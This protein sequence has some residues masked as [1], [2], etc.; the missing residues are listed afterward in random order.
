MSEKFIVSVGDVRAYDSNQNI[1]F[2]GKTLIDSSFEQTLG[3][4]PIRGGKGNALLNIYYHTGEV[5][6][7]VTDAQ[8]NLAFLAANVGQT[9]A[10]GGNI[11]VEETVTLGAAGTGTV[12]GTPI[13][14]SGAVIY[15]WLTLP[16]GT[17]ERVTFSSKTWATSTGT[18]G[19]VCCVRY[20]ALN[21]AV[22]QLTIPS[23]VV[24]SQMRLEIDTQLASNNTT[25]TNI[26]GHV[27][28]VVPA[29]QASGAFTISTKADGVSTTALNL[30][31]LRTVDTSTASCTSAPYYA[32]IT[33]IVDSA[34]WYDDVIA[35]G[36]QGG[37]VAISSGTQQLVV[38]A[39]TSTPG[40][41]P[42]Q[43]PLTGTAMT[44][45]SS[46]T[47]AATVSANGGLITK[48]ATGTTIISATITGK[49]SIDASVTCSVT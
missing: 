34:N 38:W 16:N 42:F 45:A 24:P 49:T 3:S 7:T 35:I 5:K 8:W 30:M 44:F 31:A 39:V 47:A 20:Y 19:Q 6:I 25:T 26:I 11:Y 10:T 2:V 17:T 1:L 4:T 22:S 37:D 12:V 33:E 29:A 36:I 46:D 41:A 27:Q 13:A 23:N 40:K 15:G 21:N 28:I 48:V 43:T 9:I 32:T 18:S 14:V